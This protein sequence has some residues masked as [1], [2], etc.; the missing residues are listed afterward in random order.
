MG[1]Q[2]EF[3]K[4]LDNGKRDNKFVNSKVIKSALA[5]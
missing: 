1:L 5:N 3:R 4:G 2:N